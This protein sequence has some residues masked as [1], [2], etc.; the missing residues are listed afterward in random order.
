MREYRK[1]TGG[2]QINLGNKGKKEEGE[3]RE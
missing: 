2:I 3:Y 1:N